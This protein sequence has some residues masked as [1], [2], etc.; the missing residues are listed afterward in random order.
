MSTLNVEGEAYR[1]HTKGA[2]DILKI[3]SKA[4][5]DGKVVPLT[6]ELKA[7]YLEMAEEMSDDALRVLGQPIKM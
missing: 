3:S 5:V 6:E 1:V 2:I 7:R 4:L